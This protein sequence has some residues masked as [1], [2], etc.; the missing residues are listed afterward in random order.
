MPKTDNGKVDGNIIAFRPNV[1]NNIIKYK[2][3]KKAIFLSDQFF[4]FS[5]VTYFFILIVSFPFVYVFFSYR[6]SDHLVSVTILIFGQVILTLTEKQHQMTNDYH[7]LTSERERLVQS[8]A[9]LQVHLNSLATWLGRLNDQCNCSSLANVLVLKLSTSVSFR[10]NTRNWNLITRGS[11]TSS[12]LMF[13]WWRPCF[14]RRQVQS[15]KD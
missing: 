8:C 14:W 2:T 11:W 12:N 15:K 7:V 1:V 10:K 5:F 9:A 4:F 6:F 13:N 3:R